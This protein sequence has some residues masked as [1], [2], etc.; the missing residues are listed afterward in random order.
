[1]LVGGYRL[2]GRVREAV[3]WELR[4][5]PMREAERPNNLSPMLDT[6]LDRL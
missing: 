2:L 5:P 4:L 3:V 1:M 6:V